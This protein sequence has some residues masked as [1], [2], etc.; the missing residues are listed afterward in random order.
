[1]MSGHGQVLCRYLSEGVRLIFSRGDRLAQI[2]VDEHSILGTCVDKTDIGL[3][4]LFG[5]FEYNIGAVS[6]ALVLQK[7]QVA[8]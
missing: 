5:D 6:L 2:A 4:D 1:M 3:A 7:T 8:V